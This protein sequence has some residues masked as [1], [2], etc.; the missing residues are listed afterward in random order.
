MIKRFLAE[1]THAKTASHKR[2]THHIEP[3][4]F[5]LFVFELDDECNK[6]RQ[7]RGLTVIHTC[8]SYVHSPLADS[9]DFGHLE[10]QSSPKREIPCLWRRWTTV[11]NVT[12]LALS[13]PEKSVTV[14][15]YKKA[16][17][18]TVNDISTPCL[19]TCV[20]NKQIQRDRFIARLAVQCVFWSLIDCSL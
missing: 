18:Q 4:T 20:G 8:R 9:S 10:Q 11:Q 2:E 5:V 16:N 1:C 6:Y 3:R 19:S 15:N 17:K 7:W 13:S 12:P 14:Q